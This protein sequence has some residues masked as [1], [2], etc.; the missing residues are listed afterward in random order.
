MTILASGKL[1]T[2]FFNF[3]R[4]EPV[5]GLADVIE[6]R[7]A[8]NNELLTVHPQRAHVLPGKLIHDEKEGRDDQLR[9]G[10][11][12]HRIAALGNEAQTII[13]PLVKHGKACNLRPLCRFPQVSLRE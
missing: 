9:C 5:S 6:K 7:L 3:L 10:T 1:S 11:L 12:I 4:R 13:S 2:Q 8:A